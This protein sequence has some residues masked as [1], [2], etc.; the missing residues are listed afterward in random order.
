MVD[1][2]M[3]HSLDEVTIDR[4]KREIRLKKWFLTKILSRRRSEM[5]VLRLEVKKSQ[6]KFYPMRKQREGEWER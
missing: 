6:S 3:G 1:E 4:A 2:K 5:I